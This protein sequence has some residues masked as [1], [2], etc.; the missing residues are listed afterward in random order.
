MT[1]PGILASR[2]VPHVSTAVVSTALAAGLCICDP[3]LPPSRRRVKPTLPTPLAGEYGSLVVSDPYNP[4]TTGEAAA[5]YNARL[6]DEQSAVRGR[7]ERIILSDGWIGNQLACRVDQCR[8][9]L[10]L[11]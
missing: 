4:S 1:Y 7:T 3:D 5:P 11:R 9:R 8:R 10:E 2:I 6:A